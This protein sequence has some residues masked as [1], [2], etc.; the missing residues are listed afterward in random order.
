MRTRIWSVQVGAIA[1]RRI[2]LLHAQRAFPAML[3]KV[4]LRVFAELAALMSFQRRRPRFCW[5][6]GEDRD[7]GSAQPISVDVRGFYRILRPFILVFVVIS[8][9]GRSARTACKQGRCQ[10]EKEQAVSR[11]HSPRL[12]ESVRLT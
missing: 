5:A 9:F 7:G 4:C 2:R 1:T 12:T 6:G 11:L 8:A 3:Q 10:Q